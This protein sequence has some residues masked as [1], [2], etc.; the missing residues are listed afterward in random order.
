MGKAAG[1]CCG[2]GQDVSLPNDNHIAAKRP[3]QGIGFMHRYTHTPVVSSSMFLKKNLA[4]AIAASVFSAA[5]SF[6]ETTTVTGDTEVSELSTV[7]VTGEKIARSEEKTLSSVE[8]V[9]ADELREHGDQNMQD[10]MAHTPGV[11]TQSGNENWGIRGVPVSGF[12]EQGAATMNGAISVFVDGAVQPHRLATLNPLGLW[13]V[14]QVEIFRGA[15]STTQGRNSLAGAVVLNTNDPVF[16]SEAAVQANVGKYGE[17]GA[18][19]LANGVLVDGKVAGRIAVDYQTED[20]YFR[21]ETLD[22]DANPM[23]SVNARGKLRIQPTDK[24]D[25]LLTLA[26]TELSEG[27]N[28]VHAEEGRPEYF[29]IYQNSEEEDQIDQN[30]AIAEITYALSN[31]W[32]LTS[33]TAATQTEYRSVLDYDQGPESMNEV[34]RE[35]EQQLASQEFRMAY[36][37]DRFTGFVGVYFGT[38]T[39]DIDDRLKFDEVDVVEFG[40]EDPIGLKVDG[41]VNIE[42]QAIFGEANWEFVDR[43][44]LISGLRYDRETNDTEVDYFDPLGFATVSHAEQ[45]QTFNELLPKLG[46]SHEL[47]ENQLLGLVWQRGYRGGGVD[48][49]ISTG[50]HPYDP[51]YT[52]TIELSWRGAWLDKKLRTSANLYHTDWKDQ[53]VEVSDANGIGTIVNASKARMQGLEFSTDYQLSRSL[54]FMLGAAYNKAEYVDFTYRFV[55]WDVEE[56]RGQDLSGQRFP[57]APEYKVTVGGLYTFAS[58]LQVGADV[59]H[60]ADSVT[61]A[62][63]DA[64]EITERPNDSATLVNLNADYLMTDNLS[65][66]GYVK[67]ALDKKYIVN[68]QGDDMLDVGAPRT[69]GMAARYD[70]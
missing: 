58:G 4:I 24:L 22:N 52:D 21:N 36:E 11:T 61:L 50:H 56:L 55:D 8:V 34:L 69:L 17:Q 14:E 13:D 49:S 65:L 57:F 70:F 41:D 66:R 25:V 12:D 42:N 2:I 54:R 62:T 7:I 32:T 26:R 63:N 18:S 28:G 9:T 48:L 27:T 53:Q 45:E 46:I 43:W 31:A 20:G 3:Q 15:Q 38:H 37:A 51:E 33:L 23:K 44:Q 6:A 1:R 47:T 16:R 35:H 67:N 60:Q 40:L 68:N 29:S 39:N 5:P 10:V 64:G 19:A 59:T 30:T